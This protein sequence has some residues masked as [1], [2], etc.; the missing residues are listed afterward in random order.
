MPAEGDEM[1]SP[2]SELPEITADIVERLR[3]RRPRV[4]CVTNAVAQTFTA[5][6]L[7]AAGATPSMTIA[8]DE[9]AD[10]VARANALLV[11]LGTLDANRR[12]AT[13]VAIAS[14]ANAGIPWVLDP[15]FIDRSGPRAH[16][17]DELVMQAPR[18]IRL[19]S[20][21]FSTLAGAKAD[22]GALA[23]YAREMTTVVGLTGEIDWVADGERLAKIS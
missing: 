17:A 21:E 22:A 19:N 12:E 1:R 14:A 3:A 18:A 20:A 8:A 2:A 10:F 13:G 4:H 9:I 15:V 5:N 6:M 23:R 16:F 11:N 7:L